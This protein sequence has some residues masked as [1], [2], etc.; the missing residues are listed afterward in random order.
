[1]AMKTLPSIKFS[2]RWFESNH[3]S[4]VWRSGSAETTEFSISFSN[5]YATS[6]FLISA[7]GIRSSSFHG[8]EGCLETGTLLFISGVIIMHEILMNWLLLNL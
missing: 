8:L 4:G 3:S 5:G 1:M 2:G 6:S 7:K